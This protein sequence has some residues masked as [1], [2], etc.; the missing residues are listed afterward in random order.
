MD[1]DC[2]LRGPVD[3][4]QSAVLARPLSADAW[5]ELT[6]VSSAV[7]SAGRWNRGFLLDSPFAQPA[8][9]AKPSPPEHN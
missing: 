7:V 3:Y 5:R 8:P 1:D 9:A 6:E 4:V 2:D